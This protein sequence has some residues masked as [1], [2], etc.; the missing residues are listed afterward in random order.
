MIVIIDN[1]D[2]FTYNLVRYF[3]ELGQKVEVHK[4]D[5]IS[6]ECLH[7]IDFS[8][9]VISP[10][11]CSP[12]EAGLSLA[13]IQAFWGKI[14]MLGVCLGHQAIA[15]YAGASIV[16]AAE[17]RHGK[18]STISIAEQSTLFKDCKRQFNATRYHSLIV[19]PS[20]LPT[21]FNITAWCSDFKH[22][23][24][25]AIEDS[26]NKVYGVQF[27][28]ESLLTEHGHTILNNFILSG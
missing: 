21:S 6:V 11:P 7:N 3:E 20:T 12:N 23:E 24:I 28:P 9:L 5:A 15:Q 26:I 16:R 4:N 10:G 22:R 2:S 19:D 17:I 14:P 13:I 25:M 27:H 18:I 8:H 1:Y